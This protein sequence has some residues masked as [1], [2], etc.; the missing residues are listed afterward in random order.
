MYNA[1]C[2][3]SIVKVDFGPA[4]PG[5]RRTGRDRNAAGLVWA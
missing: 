5:D 4:E 1:K 3:D 2:D